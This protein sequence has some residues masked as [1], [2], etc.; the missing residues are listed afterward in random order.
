[1]SSF[2][3]IKKNKQKTNSNNN[4]NMPNDNDLKSKN[5]DNFNGAPAQPAQSFNFNEPKMNPIND[6]QSQPKKKVLD[7]L[8]RKIPTIL[9][10]IILKK[11]I[12]L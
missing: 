11:V 9:Q 7:L 1:M 3:F 8:K 5:Q 12:L 6:N 10:E 2:K 4:G